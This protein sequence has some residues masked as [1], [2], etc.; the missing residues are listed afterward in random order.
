MMKILIENQKPTHRAG[1]FHSTAFGGG[2]SGAD[3][4]NAREFDLGIEM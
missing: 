1:F 4:G 3:G 2:D